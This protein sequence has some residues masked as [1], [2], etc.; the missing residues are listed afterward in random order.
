MF[1]TNLILFYDIVTHL[2]VEGKAVSV[3]YLDFS[4]V[5][6]TVPHSILMEKPTAHG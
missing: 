6:D 3:V 2:V 5:F 4:K 1:L